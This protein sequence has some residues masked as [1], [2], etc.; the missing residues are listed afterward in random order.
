MKGQERVFS[1][2]QPSGAQVHIG[3]Y[4]G[5]LKHFV[6]LAKH[7]ETIFCIVDL[8]ALTSVDESKELNKYIESLAAAYLAIGLDPKKTIIFRQSDVPEVCELAWYLACEF[9]LGLLERAHKVK[10][11]RTKNVSINS[12]VMFYPILMAADILLYRAHKVPVGADQKQHL[13]MARDVAERFN[14]RRGDIFPVPEPLI[15]ENSAVITG[16]DGR[17]MSKSYDNY[18]GLFEDSKSVRKKVMRI[19]TDSKGVEDIKDPDS[20]N[21]FQL[22]KHFSSTDEQQELRQRY[23]A[24]GMGYGVAKEEVFKVIEREINPLRQVYNDLIKRPNDLRDVLADGA[25]RARV[26]AQATI[27]DVRDA[28]GVGAKL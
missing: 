6:T 9:P 28:V 1:G 27:A 4:A 18:I 12:G 7:Y 2:V 8:H 25:K 20:C 24:G 3:N 11:S 15:D 22:Y 26:I 16:L 5:A 21:I 17:K 14:F 19:V 23:L 13:E 10:D